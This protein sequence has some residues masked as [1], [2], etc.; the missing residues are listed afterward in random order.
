[1]KSFTLFLLPTTWGILDFLIPFG[2]PFPSLG[3]VGL[4]VAGAEGLSF[5]ELAPVGVT[6]L[7]EQ[8]ALLRFTCVGASR[9]GLVVEQAA[10]LRP[11]GIG[12]SGVGLV[13][14]VAL[15]GTVGAS[16]GS[17]DPVGGL[18]AEQAALQDFGASG[19]GSSLLITSTG[20]W[21]L[22]NFSPSLS[23]CPPHTCW[24]G[25][26]LAPTPPPPSAVPSVCGASVG[27]CF[28]TG[29]SGQA[30][31]TGSS[32]AGAPRAGG[33]S[34]LVGQALVQAALSGSVGASG[35]GLG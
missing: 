25:T 2:V 3:F 16:W 32:V 13:G 26:N 4:G 14:Q 27:S 6:P 28:G 12:A 17:S 18:G 31:L 11:S 35:V 33:A 24:V 7:T 9:A 23:I 29:A 22:I 34:L 19:A 30:A 10:L 1:M 20:K 21:L 5:P 15:P 8:A